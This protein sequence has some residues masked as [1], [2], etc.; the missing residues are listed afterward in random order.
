MLFPGRNEKRI[1]L[2]LMK[3]LYV[4]VLESV[5]AIAE[6]ANSALEKRGWIP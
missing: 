1:P 4:M 3:V 2:R 5:P 6:C